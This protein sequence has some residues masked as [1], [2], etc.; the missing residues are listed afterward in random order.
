M[1]SE[2]TNLSLQNQMILM[3]IVLIIVPALYTMIRA[4]VI[5]SKAESMR[6]ERLTRNMYQDF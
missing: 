2:L 5:K 3:L 4:L 6:E 1:L